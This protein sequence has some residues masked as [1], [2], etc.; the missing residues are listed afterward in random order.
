[1]AS[2]EKEGDCKTDSKGKE[3]QSA[4]G[5]SYIR[6]FQYADRDSRLLYATS[7]VAAIGAGVALPFMDLIFGKFVTTFNNFAI[8]VL[9]P[10]GYMSEVEKFT[11]YFVYLFIAKFVLTYIHSF[12]VSIAA[13][14]TTKAL[15]EHFL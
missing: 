3:G 4:G 2:N 15:R 9:S 11:L 13:I 6:V 8:G 1:M 7:C 10:S 12:C 14:K 5:Q